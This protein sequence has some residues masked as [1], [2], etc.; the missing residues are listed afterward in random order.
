MAPALLG[1]VLET[2]TAAGLVAV[3]ITEVEAYS[4]QTDPASHAYRRKSGRNQV[5]FGP[6][7]YAYVYQIYGLHFC[8]NL[9][10]QPAGTAEAVLLRAGQ[11]VDGAEVA[12]T[13]RASARTELQLARGR[14]CCARCWPSTAGSTVPTCVPRT[15]RY[16][17]A[18]RARVTRPRSA[19]SG[20]GPGSG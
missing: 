14:P 4:G 16:A 2:D 18:G 19:R 9:V 10:C 5:M 6:P 3:R 1:C 15:R 17:C 8:V 20:A 13:R 7:G 12:W 11:V